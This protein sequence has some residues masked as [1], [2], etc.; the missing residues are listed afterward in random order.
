MFVTVCT[1]NFIVCAQYG[2]NLQG[3]YVG[4]TYI[5][6]TPFPS[7]PNIKKYL[8]VIVFYFIYKKVTKH[9][10]WDIKT[11]EIPI[12]S[13]NIQKNIHFYCEMLPT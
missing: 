10:S 11:E 13:S 2:N 8:G 3:F 6:S 9:S 12:T 4:N 5:Y 1:K 7:P